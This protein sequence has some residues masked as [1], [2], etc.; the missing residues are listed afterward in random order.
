MKTI[1]RISASLTMFLSV[2]VFS[3]CGDKI[4]YLSDYLSGIEPGEDVM[5]AIREALAVCRETNARTLMLPPGELTI[6]PDLAY[7]DYQFIS[8]NTESLKRIAFNLDGMDDFVIE[9]ENTV[10]MFTGFIS[11]FSLQNCKN[12]TIK[13]LS[14]D[15]TRTFHSEGTIAATGNGWMDI[16]FPNDYKC[17]IE[18][19]KLYFYDENNIR[20]NYSS[21]LEFDVDKKEPAYL[22]SD[23]WLYDEIEAKRLDGNLIR[24]YREDLKGNVG[25]IMVFGASGRY[26]PAFFVSGSDRIN[27]EDVTLYH[28][29]GMGVI[30]QNSSDIV[31]ER[32]KVLPAEGRMISITADA[33]HFVNCRGN[34]VMKNCEFR[35]QKDDATNIHGWYMAVDEVVSSKEVILEWRN[36]GQYGINFIIPGM[37]M[38]LVD[39][40]TL[41]TLGV[42]TVASVEYLNKQR[43]RVAFSEILPENIRENMVMGED[44]HSPDVLIKDCVFSGNRARGLLIGSRGKVTIENNEFHIAG[45]AILFEGDGNYWF[46]Q[47]GV[48]DVHI[49][50]NVFENCNYG[51]PTW[52]KACISVGSGIPDMNSG[53]YYHRNI[54]IE[55]NLFKGFDPRILH[56]Y[57]VDGLLFKNNRIEMTQD[58]PCPHPY[59]QHFVYNGCNDINIEE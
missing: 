12:I 11:P 42:V 19:G 1:S 51:S 22:A 38:E 45:A 17:G 24:I 43:V 50:N 10:L 30:A 29:G 7:E 25:N 2:A 15:Y 58:Y 46:E 55:N 13:G 44:L 36:Y 49:V 27:I 33:T 5:P 34:V 14:V 21:L 53:S 54:T 28:C 9:G 41:K 18:D 26:N 8:N 37:A 39:N 32:L 35:N 40:E 4:V 52:G 23:Y 57:S 47:S 3:S 59:A 31:L 6:L 16:L 56:L 20:Y 48:R